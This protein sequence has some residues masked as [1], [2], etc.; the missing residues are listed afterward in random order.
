MIVYF[1][2]N[3]IYF[4]QNKS[5]IARSGINIIAQTRSNNKFFLDKSQVKN[6]EVFNERDLRI[7]LIDGNSIIWYARIFPKKAAQSLAIKLSSAYLK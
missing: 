2:E 7:N 3:R 4:I 1:C 5:T 6:V